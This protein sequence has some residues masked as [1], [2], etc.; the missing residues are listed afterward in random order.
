MSDRTIANSSLDNQ[1]KIKLKMA[2]N[3]RMRLKPGLLMSRE[4]SLERLSTTHVCEKLQDGFGG[5]KRKQI[6]NLEEFNISRLWNIFK[7]ATQGH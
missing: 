7:R 3:P 6:S 2:A 1:N 4:L 5:G